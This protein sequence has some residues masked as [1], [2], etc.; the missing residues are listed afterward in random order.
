MLRV[1]SLEAWYGQTQAL[2]K[3][4]LELRQGEMVAVLGRNGAG[5]TTLMRT[6]AG[7]Q[8]HARGEVTFNGRN[9]LGADAAEIARAGLSFVREG[10]RMA[11]SLTV[12]QHLALG[13]GLAKRRGLTSEPFDRVWQTFPLLQPL[14]QRPAGLLSGG[15]RQA[16]ALAIAFISKP[17]LILIDEPSAGLAQSVVHELYQTLGALTS[18][19]TTILIVEQQPSWLIGLAGRGY[20]LDIG[21]VIGKGAVKDLLTTAV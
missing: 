3:I 8:P 2:W 10:G 11:S 14:Q 16:L 4:D 7:L 1:E 9:I 21:K 12:L 19:G 5:K 15:Q 6:I 20:V 13:Q 18:F 17:K